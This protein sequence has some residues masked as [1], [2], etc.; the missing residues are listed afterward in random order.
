MA[1]PRNSLIRDAVLHLK[2][3]NGASF[4]EIRRHLESNYSNRLDPT[5]KRMLSMALKGLV[6]A[7]SVE[8][9]SSV[10]KLGIQQTRRAPKTTD[11][12]VPLRRRRGL[13][14]RRRKVQ[15][16]RRPV[17]RRQRRGSRRRHRR[18]SKRRRVQ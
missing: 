11:N 4:A 5:N 2:Q 14:V 18:H 9:R 16:S 12:P 15:K 1:T 6:Q 17:G 10:Y 7:G 8:R 3:R 13:A